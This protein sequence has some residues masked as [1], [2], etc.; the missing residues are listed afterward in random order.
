MNRDR[1]PRDLQ[2]HKFRAYG[3]LKNLRFF[4]AFLVLF[5]RDAGL[6]FLEIGVLYSIREICANVL[7]IPTGVLA[8][9]FGRRRAMVAA[10]ASYL[11]SFAVFYV[12]H[13]FAA[14]AGAMVLFAAGEALRSGTHKA[15]ILEHLTLRGLCDLKVAYY[16]RTRAASQAGSAVAALVAAGLVF[17]TGNYRIVFGASMIPYVLGLVLMISYPRELDGVSDACDAATSGVARHAV[18]STVRQFVSVLRHPGVLRG[19]VNASSFDAVFKAS[20]DYLQP[21]LQSQALAIPLLVAHDLDA[22]AAVLVGVMYAAIYGLTSL[23]ASRSHDIQRRAEAPTRAA[24]LTYAVGLGALA[25]AGFAAAFGV[26]WA[27][28]AAFVLVFVVQN[29]RRPMIVGYLSD[30]LPRATMAT[31]L[32]VEAQLQ[33]LGVAAFAPLLGW[34]ADRVGVGFAVACVAV[35]G[36]LV[37]SATALRE[38]TKKPET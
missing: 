29:V 17:Y 34:I 22:R 28:V 8:D 30:A 36:L 35:V 15:M 10:F 5:L 16:G 12:S 25:A 31:G 26:L 9:T 24:N 23:A 37:G 2:Y 33:T 11:A 18:R 6:S 4:D 7:E 27:A 3:F 20:K 1:F 32:S 14:F 21:I 38:P 13:D 19:L